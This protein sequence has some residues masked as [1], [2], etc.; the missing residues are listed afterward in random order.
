MPS[1]ESV[2]K[3]VF[4]LMCVFSLSHANIIEVFLPN[5]VK[6]ENFEFSSF[7]ELKMFQSIAHQAAVS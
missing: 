7:I 2:T 5:K 4:V 1:I 3:I 6:I